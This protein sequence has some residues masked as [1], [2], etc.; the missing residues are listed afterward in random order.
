MATHSSILA[1]RIHGQRSLVGYSLWGLQESDTTKHVHRSTKE[2]PASD[3]DRI[4]VL[5]PVKNA[6]TTAQLHSSHML[7]K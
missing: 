5:L 1:W 3:R 6:Q 7:V 4:N 2:A